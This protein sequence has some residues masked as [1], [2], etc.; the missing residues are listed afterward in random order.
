MGYR[1][2]KRSRR[3]L[4]AKLNG[5]GS[6]IEAETTNGGITFTDAKVASRP[7]P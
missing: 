7:A 2:R 5:G 6:R 4:E 1:S 3:R